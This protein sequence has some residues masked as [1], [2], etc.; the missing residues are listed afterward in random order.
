M[1]NN[2]LEIISW[3]DFWNDMH[4]DIKASLSRVGVWVDS[5]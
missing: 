2:E 1:P 4:E 5:K 3:E